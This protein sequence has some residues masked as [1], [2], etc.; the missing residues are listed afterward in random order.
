MK[1][2]NENSRHRRA[3]LTTF[4]CPRTAVQ[5]ASSALHRRAGTVANTCRSVRPRPRLC[6]A[7][8]SQVLRAALASGGTPHSAFFPQLRVRPPEVGRRGNPGRSLDDCRGGWA[9][10]CAKNARTAPRRRR[11][12]WRGVSLDK[13]SLKGARAFPAPRPCWSRKHVAPHGRVGCGDA[14]EV[15]KA[16][17]G[18]LQHLGLR[19]TFKLIRPCPTIVISDQMRQ[20]AGDGEHHVM[21][22]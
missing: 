9:A 20:M 7:T 12:G 8:A 13:S 22:V 18:E 2:E 6:S 17:G 19:D 15:A 14:R 11:G 1:I 5:A 21:M 4:L 16:A 3:A 10:G